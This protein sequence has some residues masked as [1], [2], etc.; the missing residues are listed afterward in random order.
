MARVLTL[1]YKDLEIPVIL[2]GFSRDVLYG[3]SI[4]EK[5]GE[6]GTVYQYANLTL[7]G[8]QFVNLWLGKPIKALVMIIQNILFII[9]IIVKIGK[10]Q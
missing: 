8:T 6:D 5:R 1:H 2:K 3:K 9:W 7:D 4:I 10:L